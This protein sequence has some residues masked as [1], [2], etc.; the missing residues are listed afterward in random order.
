[1]NDERS[2]LE[3]SSFEYDFVRLFPV[4]FRGY[5]ICGR[6]DHFCREYFAQGIKNQTGIKLFMNEVWAHK[7]HT[8]TKRKS[9]VGHDNF[10]SNQNVNINNLNSSHFRNSTGNDI[11]LS[12]YRPC[13]DKGPEY[14]TPNRNRKVE[15]TPAWKKRNNS[16]LREE[17][18]TTQAPIFVILVGLFE[19]A[20]SIQPRTM[21]LGLYNSLPEIPLQFGTSDAE[22]VTLFTHSYSCAAMNVDNI[23]LHQWIITTKPDI[24]HNYI[25]FDD[26]HPFDPITLIC[27]KG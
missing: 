2:D 25:Q 15:K 27:E 4:G 1:M 9:A 17:D 20:E 18:G 3:R 7:P 19:C 26:E 10:G 12:S 13:Y 23:A 22:E 11:Y 24:F 14:D 6:E 8:N 16:E 21:P 5:Y